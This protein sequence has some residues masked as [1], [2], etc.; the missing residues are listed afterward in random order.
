MIKQTKNGASSYQGLLF[1][2]ERYKALMRAMTEWEPGRDRQRQ[3]IQ[4]WVHFY[5]E[6]MM[7]KPT[8][9]GNKLVLT[10]SRGAERE[11]PTS[12][13]FYLEAENAPK[14]GNHAGC[15]TLQMY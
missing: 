4:F 11:Y 12:P 5:E 2:R 8:E 15:T 14:S 6:Y 3:L 7:A 9:A 1:N 13:G 10:S